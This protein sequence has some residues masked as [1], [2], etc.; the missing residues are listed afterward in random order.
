MKKPLQVQNVR[1][2]LVMLSSCS[3]KMFTNFENKFLHIFSYIFV[4]FHL[5]S[6]GFKIYLFLDEVNVL[7]LS[8]N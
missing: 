3:K 7:S 5:S 6:T 1:K 8:N 2:I 4:F